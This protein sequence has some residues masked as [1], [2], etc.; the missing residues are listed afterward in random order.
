MSSTCARLSRS[1]RF[2]S[3]A[4]SRARGGY[5]SGRIV[6]ENFVDLPARVQ[7]D[8]DDEAERLALLYVK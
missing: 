2:S 3:T 1:T 5:D 7:R 6:T 4:R 8:V